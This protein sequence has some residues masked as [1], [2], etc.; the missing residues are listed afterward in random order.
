MENEGRITRIAYII[1]FVI[2]A[3]FVV[4]RALSSFGLLNFLGDY[5][6]YVFSFVIQ[7]V[8]LLGGSVFLFAKLT[9]QKTKQVLVNYGVIKISS[10]T[11]IWAIVAG[12]IVFFLNV[13]ISSFF[14]S[15]ISALGYTSER[16][17]RVISNYPVWL[18]FVNIIFT[19]VLPAI[20][21]EMAHRG[22][23]LRASGK[24]GFIKAILISS[25]LFGLLHLNIEQVFYATL[26]GVYL[27]FVT[28]LSGSIIPAMIIHFMNNALS[29]FLNYSAF[30]GLSFG[31]I[32]I[33]VNL[34]LSNNLFLG[35]LFIIILVTLLM[36][37][38]LYVSKKLVVSGAI[39]KLKKDREF[40]D[41]FYKRHA[42][43]NETS[44]TAVNETDGKIVQ[45]VFGGV[46]I[47]KMDFVTKVMFCLTVSMLFVLTVF[48][49]VWGVI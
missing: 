14:N 37:A 34:M 13:F 44:S 6:G 30:K 20:C 7:V 17:G 2:A 36:Y 3:L 33:K 22:M 8:L 24:F 35:I 12:A 21:E 5:G 19:A 10:K 43:F 42:F 27:G 49:F 32:F 23:I 18:L 26:I 47:E 4:I 1:Y 9:K 16:A 29:V 38:L 11:I 25:L 31:S 46:K 15:I 48:T 39:D 40:L 28:M 45:I 41:R